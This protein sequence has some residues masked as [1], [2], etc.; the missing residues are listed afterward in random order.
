MIGI[1]CPRCGSDESTVTNTLHS[2]VGRVRYRKCLDCGKQH[3]TIEQ[4]F[5]YPGTE[6]WQQMLTIELSALLWLVENESVTSTPWVKRRIEV[7]KQELMNGKSMR[8]RYAKKLPEDVV[9]ALRD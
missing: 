9:A 5:Y 3:R 4:N 2:I 7:V 6:D 1:R 8:G